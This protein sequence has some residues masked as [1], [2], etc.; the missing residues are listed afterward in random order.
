MTYVL[1]SSN[2]SSNFSSCLEDYLLQK[3]CTWVDISVHLEIGPVYNIWVSDLYFILLPY[4]L[5]TNLKIS[6]NKD[7]APARSIRDPLGTCSSE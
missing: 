7:I 6:Y 5:V 4:I 1:W 3:S 2:F